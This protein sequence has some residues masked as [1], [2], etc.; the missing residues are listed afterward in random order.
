[1]NKKITSYIFGILIFC[2]LFLISF[3][4]IEL[5]TGYFDFGPP[6]IPENY[7][8][9]FCMISLF[10]PIITG[11]IVS[12]QFI[13]WY[14]RRKDIKTIWFP[15]NKSIKLIILGL[16]LLTTFAG[17]PSVQSYNTKWAVDE[18]KRINTG[19]NSRVWETHPYIRT[20][21]A[22]PILPFVVMSYHEYQL[23]GLYGLGSWDIQLWY[24]AGV[25]RVFR[26]PLWIS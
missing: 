22:I 20:Y 26:I 3:A 25:K 16:Y 5:V 4:I 9:L 14:E 2:I 15:R 10:V 24:F 7:M 12:R 13:K 6:S 8:P 18:Y 19:E 1:M 11:F 23:D 17:I 21:L